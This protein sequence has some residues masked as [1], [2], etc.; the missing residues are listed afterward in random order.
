MPGP[1]RGVARLCVY[2]GVVQ[3][4]LRPSFCASSV[5]EKASLSWTACYSH[6]SPFRDNGQLTVKDNEDR[7]GEESVHG[8]RDL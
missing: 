2:G 3:G 4:W 1:L 6:K 5:G 8:E 7:N